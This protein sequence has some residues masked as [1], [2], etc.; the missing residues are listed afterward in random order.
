MTESIMVRLKI[1]SGASQNEIVGWYG[2]ALKVRLAATATKGRANHELCKYL[3][4][5]LG[6]S[7]RDITIKSGLTSPSKM[8]EVSTLSAQRLYNLLGVTAPP[9]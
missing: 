5:R 3:A 6:V 1:V 4:S 8:V 7:R 2:G 9:D